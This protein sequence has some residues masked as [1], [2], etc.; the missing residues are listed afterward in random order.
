MGEVPLAPVLSFAW[1]LASEPSWAEVPPFR[2]Q[3]PSRA[4]RT[5]VPRAREMRAVASP[6]RQAGGLPKRTL[7]LVQEALPHLP[8]EP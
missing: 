2:A 1:P 3:F 4:E 8:C 5:T 6:L 7:Y